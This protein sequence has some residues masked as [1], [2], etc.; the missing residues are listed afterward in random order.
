MASVIFLAHFIYSIITA[1]STHEPVETYANPN[2]GVGL[3]LLLFAGYNL[4]IPYEHLLAI[5]SL[6]LLTGLF[7]PF[8]WQLSAIGY[9]LSAEAEADSR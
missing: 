5:L 3:L 8:S 1:F 6:T 4:Q 7:K 9:Q 2:T